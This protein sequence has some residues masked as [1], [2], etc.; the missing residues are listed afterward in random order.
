M[1]INIANR[2]GGTHFPSPR[3]GGPGKK[4]SPRRGGS[5]KKGFGGTSRSEVQLPHRL[6]KGLPEREMKLCLYRYFEAFRVVQIAV[7]PDKGKELACGGEGLL[8]RVLSEG[9]ESEVNCGWEP[10]APAC[11]NINEMASAADEWQ[12]ASSQQ[13]RLT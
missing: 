6:G 13:A 3:R 12:V 5:G 9:E 7:G 1:N 2:K 4:G 11:C 8:K 10:E